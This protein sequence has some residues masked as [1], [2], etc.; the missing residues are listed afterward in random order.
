MIKIGNKYKNKTKFWNNI[1]ITPISW[2][3]HIT[4]GIHIN[5]SAVKRHIP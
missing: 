4:V 1:K 3:K 2:L 5:F